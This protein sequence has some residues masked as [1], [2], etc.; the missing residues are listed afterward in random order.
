VVIVRETDHLRLP[1]KAG[2]FDPKLPKAAV[3]TGFVDWERRAHLV[4]T[5]AGRAERRFLVRYHANLGLVTHRARHGE[6]EYWDSSVNPQTAHPW[7]PQPSDH[8][9]V[10]RERG[11]N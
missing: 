3:T 11:S 1:F 2:Q 5:V 9:P 10:L 8:R 4:M 7:R 6:Q